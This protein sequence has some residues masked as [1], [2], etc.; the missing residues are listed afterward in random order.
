[1]TIKF[2]RPLREIF[3]YLN[4][5]W[6]QFRLQTALNT[7]FGVLTVVAD[8]AFVWI[9]KMAIDVATH[10]RTDISLRH[11]CTLLVFTMAL[12]IALGV[13]MKWIRATLGVRSR[14]RMQQRIFK[15]LMKCHWTGLKKHHTGH[16]V[17]RLERD[18][19]DVV[20]F[21]TEGIPSFV[22][23]FTKFIGAFFILFLMDRTLACIIVLIVPFFLL[24]GK[25][26][27]KRMRKLTHLV[28]DSES[29][30]Q[31]SLQ[32]SLQNFMVIK[33]LERTEEVSKSIAQ[34]QEVLHREVIRKTKYTTLSST[35]MNIGFGT[36]Y[37]V[38][39]I[40]GAVSL[41]NGAITYGAMLA[42]I[43][44]VGQ[45]QTPVRNLTQF[46]PIFIGAFTATE[47]LMELD[48]IPTETQESGC[49]LATSAGI[50]L[51]GV[52]Y[53]YELDSRLIFKNFDF[54]FPPGSITAIVGE[55][56]AGKTTLIRLILA[57]ISPS[58]GKID[59]YDRQGNRI[60]VSPA[61]RCNLSYVPQGNTL[62]SGTIRSNLLLGNP[63]ATEEEM[64]EALKCAAAH[65]VSDLP[66]GLD[67]RCG[68]A[69]VDYRKGR[70][71]VSP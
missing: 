59:L 67:T 39:F 57:L 4:A 51:Q 22:T 13:T 46:I 2:T 70:H 32:E 25:F 19:G 7:S 16:L 63:D 1:M 34:Q 66:N 10:T 6:Q 33:T 64:H 24:T 41:E 68:E 20:F 14:N 11:A 26:Y 43:Q 18:V 23:T 12:Q 49:K 35:M 9:T 36:G 17:N 8:L 60:T 55:T 69:E 3:R 31:A 52:N 54:D 62:L 15:H 50:R 40:W 28:R 30:I 61:T 37:L 58:K 65:F 44:L 21:L 45:I 56:G 53:R 48:E 47:R 5:I 29:R 42:F 38:T 27:M 71:N